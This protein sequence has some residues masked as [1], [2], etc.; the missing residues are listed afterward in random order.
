MKQL[1]LLLAAALMTSGF[2][3]SAFAQ[4][5]DAIEISEEEI[6]DDM[7]LPEADLV[8]DELIIEGDDDLFVEEVDEPLT[9]ETLADD[10]MIQDALDQEVSGES[11][12]QADEDDLMIIEEGLE[13]PSVEKGVPAGIAPGVPPKAGRIDVGAYEDVLK[14]NLDLRREV[15]DLATEN[16]ELSNETTSLKALL[17][18]MDKQVADSI[19][20][21][22]ELKL[23]KSN[24]DA[25]AAVAQKKG[26]AAPVPAGAGD[27]KSIGTAA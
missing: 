13:T 15:D 24:A 7:L 5:N 3:S 25:R 16:D 8:E 17:K 23:A 26:G 2:G 14:E 21:I 20:M 10:A 22:Q 11:P 19:G 18:D 1:S 6:L 4:G 12:W 27:G 9:P